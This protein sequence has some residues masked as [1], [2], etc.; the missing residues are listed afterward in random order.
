[1]RRRA[2]RRFHR[3][4]G[5]ASVFGRAPDAPTVVGADPAVPQRLLRA[6][7]FLLEESRDGGATWRE[8]SCGLA[9]ANPVRCVF[10]AER[11]GTVWLLG[12]TE[13]LVS[14][15]GGIVWETVPLPDGIT[16]DAPARDMALPTAAAPVLTSDRR[17]WRRG[18][19]DGEWRVLWHHP[20]TRAD[21]FRLWFHR[22]HTGRWGPPLVARLHDLAAYVVLL[23]VI[24]GLLLYVRR[25]RRPGNGPPA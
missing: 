11:P 20:P 14:H 10:A 9:P 24:S 6:S 1:V 8:L 17:A 2:Y 19:D 5:L 4:I 16:W 25:N 23:A 7:P 15:D 18:A 21:G 3:W 22:L 12:A 13:L